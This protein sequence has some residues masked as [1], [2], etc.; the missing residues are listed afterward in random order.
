MYINCNTN[1]TEIY[2]DNNI[3]SLTNDNLDKIFIL[4]YNLNDIL[5]ENE[6]LNN[7]SYIIINN[8]ENLVYKNIFYLIVFI[9]Y[10]Y[11]I[12]ILYKTIG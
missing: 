6:I 12:W 5:N 9:V 4:K 10:I 1:G 11:M 7:L 2:F 8:N 3:I